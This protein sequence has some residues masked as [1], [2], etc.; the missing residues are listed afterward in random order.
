MGP[1]KKIAYKGSGWLD[2]LQKDA[3]KDEMDHTNTNPSFFVFL[4]VIQPIV[5]CGIAHWFEIPLEFAILPILSHLVMFFVS[6]YYLKTCNSFDITGETTFFPLIV[7]S[8][9]SGV[10]GTR[11]TLVTVL[12][13][14]WCT[15]L[16]IFLGWRIMSRGSDWRFDKL[17]EAPAYNC[18]G[19]VAQ[20]TWIFLQGFAIWH[21]HHIAPAQSDV[22]GDWRS[23]L[24]IVVWAVGMGCEHTADMQKTA[25]NAKTKSGRQTTW[26][27][28][29][30]WKY[31]RHPNFFGENTNWLG[32]FIASGC[33]PVAFVSPFWSWFFLVF[34]SLMLLEKR[35]D[36]KFGGKAEYEAYKEGTSVLVPWFVREGVGEKKKISSGRNTP[37]RK[38]GSRSKASK[39]K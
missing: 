6:H 5:C 9:W 1:R 11:S 18:F 39:S 8:H 15:R 14:I 27:R 2:R 38:S 7:Y 10:G 34:T 23:Y 29:G 37:K 30:L 16:G 36:K 32:I 35:L 24:G 3:Q 28:E 19:W 25:W 33:H 20:G 4:T 12:S 22:W 13:L 26:I 21:T 31:S 17:M